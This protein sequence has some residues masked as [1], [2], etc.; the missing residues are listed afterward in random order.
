MGGK[1]R[2]LVLASKW[3]RCYV[4]VYEAVGRG[5]PVRLLK[6]LMTNACSNNCLYCALRAHSAKQKMAWR[7][8]KL[9]LSLIHI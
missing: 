7:P 2:L 6:T 4:P 1:W 5:R 3:D 8:D 9:A